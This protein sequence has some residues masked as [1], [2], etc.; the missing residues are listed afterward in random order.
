MTIL[1]DLESRLSTALAAT[2]W[3]AERPGPGIVLFHMCNSDR[4]A[5]AGLGERLAAR[6]FHVL[7]L[8]YRGYGESGGVRDQKDPA[9][10]QRIITEQW[11]GDA[12]AA[13]DLLAARPG[14]D[15]TR[16]G[17]AGG[18]CGVNQA[19]QL[20]RRHPEVRALVLLAGN[21]NGA[22]RDFLAASP[23]LP[24]FA[25][26][27]HDDGGAVEGMRW[28]VG[29]SSNPA[30]RMVV[31]EKG[32]HGTEMFAVH[33]DLEPAIVDF[34]EE[35]L[36]RRPAAKPADAAAPA[37]GGPSAQLEARL[38]E[39]GAAAKLRAE[40]R[41]A[42]GDAAR[43]GLAPEGVVNLLGYEKLQA[44]D[45]AGAIELFLL[46]VEAYPKSANAHDSLA[47]GYL[48]AGDREKAREHAEKAIAA[49]AGDPNQTAEFQK[50]IRDAAEAKLRQLAEAVK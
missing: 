22:G 42:G 15:R 1:Q 48:A 37:R 21:T 32:G 29:Y 40:L 13:F 33:A 35:H 30:N 44:G 2:L 24:L 23:W 9:H 12:D 17:A 6:G 25:S 27:A 26:A 49:L 16:I 3:S 36:V 10:Q 7:A 5:W 50:A 8:D 11:P 31:Y 41:A 46:N 34:F 45:A 28:L 14:V 19:V 38:R 18:S 43:V 39:P 20:A 47:D 4:S